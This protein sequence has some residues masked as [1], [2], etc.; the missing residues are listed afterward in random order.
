MPQLPDY[1]MKPFDPLK[2]SLSS[3]ELAVKKLMSVY[4]LAVEKATDDLKKA[5]DDFI[6][7]L[8]KIYPDGS[9]K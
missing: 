5:N 7:G 9:L 3:N 1:I 8:L 4:Y 6:K 2:T